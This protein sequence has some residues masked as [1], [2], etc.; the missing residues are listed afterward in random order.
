MYLSLEWCHRIADALGGERPVVILPPIA[1]TVTTY[2]AG[3]AGTISLTPET[4]AAVLKDYLDSLARHGPATIALVNS[5][6]EPGHVKLLETAAV[7]PRERP[8]VLFVNHCRKPWALELG[9]EFKSGDCHAGCYETSLMLA[10]RYRDLVKMDVARTLPVANHGLVAKMKAGVKTFEEMGATQAYF[11]D[12]AAA[13][14]EEGER[15]WGVL[16]WMWVETIRA[17][18]T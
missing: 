13:T 12:P 1:Q 6:L 16:V 14:V 15:L 18:A 5:H 10:G 9:E 11:G 7:A 4:A 17:A 3:F 2:A 8:R